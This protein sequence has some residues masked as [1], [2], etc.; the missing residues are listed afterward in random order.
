MDEIYIWFEL[1]KRRVIPN[2]ES[3][4]SLTNFLFISISCYFPKVL[5]IPIFILFHCCTSL[6]YE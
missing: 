4:E 3:A 6:I 1:A 5:N 2:G